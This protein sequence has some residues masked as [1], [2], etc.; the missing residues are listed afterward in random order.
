[1]I[2]DNPMND[3]G[4]AAFARIMRM[5]YDELTA[6]RKKRNEP[7]WNEGW[8]IIDDA[9]HIKTLEDEAALLIFAYD[10]KAVSVLEEW[11]SLCHEA[12]CDRIG[13]L[14]WTYE[15]VINC[16]DSFYTDPARKEWLA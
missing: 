10:S 15:E 2:T 14:P 16:I 4:N 1:M 7:D 3:K 8:S 6:E 11:M 12:P 5:Y 9:D 13:N